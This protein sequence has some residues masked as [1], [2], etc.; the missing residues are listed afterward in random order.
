MLANPP[1]D[2]TTSTENVPGSSAPAPNAMPT[3]LLVEDDNYVS[4][5][6]WTLLKYSNF[7][8]T[9]AETGTEGLKLVGT[10][11]PHI[12]ILDVNLP[13]INGLEI[14][15]R[16]KADPATSHLPVVFLSARIEF[17]QEAIAVGAEIFLAKPNDV[18]RLADTLS[19]I[20]A[21]R[22]AAQ[23]PQRLTQAAVP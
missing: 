10:L 23:T 4:A 2:T 17:A 18:S 22:A 3:V 9:I 19:Q 6:I 15:R 8:V 5:A 14:C 1:V 11:S 20:L 21:S 16:L 13:D 7:D 12:I